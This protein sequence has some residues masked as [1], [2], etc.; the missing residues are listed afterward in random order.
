MW[1]C[2]V[3][4]FSLCTL[5]H[6]NNNNNNNKSNNNHQVLCLIKVL[7]GLCSIRVELN[8]LLWACQSLFSGDGFPHEERTLKNSFPAFSRT[9][10]CGSRT[11]SLWPTTAISSTLSTQIFCLALDS[12]RLFFSSLAYFQNRHSWEVWGWSYQC[13]GRLLLASPWYITNKQFL[14][15]SAWYW[16]F[17]KSCGE[18]GVSSPAGTFLRSTASKQLCRCTA[19][20]ILADVAVVMKLYISGNLEKMAKSKS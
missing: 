14:Y 1:S 19:I 4:S 5:S 2:I 18:M 17:W 3:R 7:T 15:F 11:S 8:A 16:D 6:R 10:L 9:L 12:H 20:F 13:H